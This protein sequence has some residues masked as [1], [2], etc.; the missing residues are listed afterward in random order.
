M[1]KLEEH[2]SKSMTINWLSLENVRER[3]SSAAYHHLADDGSLTRRV[4]ERCTGDFSVRL[5]D[6]KTCPCDK[7][8]STLLD[9]PELAPVF[10]RQ[11]F[12]CCDGRPRIFARTLIGLTEKNK[13]L[14]RQVMALGENSLGS[15]LFRDP[16]AIKKQMHLAQIPSHHEFSMQAD[17][18]R[19]GG[20]AFIWVRR[21]LFQYD[22][23]DL[24]VYEAFI[25]FPVLSQEIS[26][27][28]S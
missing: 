20:E 14:T 15:I 19:Q 3:L 18:P 21:S 24:I 11:A 6:H 1:T 12:L 23:R 13:D 9:L 22:D 4:R 28:S 7:E 25:D 26:R 17:L 8:A 2:D 27:P 10:S 16:H 5:I